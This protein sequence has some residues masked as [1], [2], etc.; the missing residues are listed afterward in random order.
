MFSLEVHAVKYNQL[1][2]AGRYHVRQNRQTEISNENIDDTEFEPLSFID[3][4]CA[5]SY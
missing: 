1:T 2:A 3:I 5:C 4:L